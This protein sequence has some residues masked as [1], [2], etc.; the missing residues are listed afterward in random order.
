MYGGYLELFSLAPC[1]YNGRMV[2]HALWLYWGES[3]GDV[4]DNMVGVFADKI[5]GL[6]CSRQCVV[7]YRERDV[8]HCGRRSESVRPCHDVLDRHEREDSVV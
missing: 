7:G 4:I 3:P 2:D 1:L 6:L 5:Y 8:C